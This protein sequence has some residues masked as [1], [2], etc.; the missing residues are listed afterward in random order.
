MK[1]ILLRDVARL[2]KRHAVVVVPDGYALNKLLPQGMAVPATPENQK[3]V[4]NQAKETAA[5]KMQEAE[6]IKSTIAAVVV[7]P[8]T[9]TVVAN[10][11]GHLFKQIKASDIVDA[12]TKRGLV[13]RETHITLAEPIKTI[14]TYDVPVHHGEVTGTLSVVITAVN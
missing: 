12:A 11:Q 7:D 13:L 10:E 8:L 2:G 6:S 4:V 1:V 5:G 9:I 14:G 3:R